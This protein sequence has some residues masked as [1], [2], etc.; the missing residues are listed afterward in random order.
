MVGG[1]RRLRTDHVDKT[2]RV[3]EILNIQEKFLHSVHVL[4]QSQCKILY[5]LNNGDKILV[6]T[7]RLNI[8]YNFHLCSESISSGSI[9]FSAIKYMEFIA[10]TYNRSVASVGKVKNLDYIGN[11]SIII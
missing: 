8:L 6:I 2:D 3:R 4:E 11:R 1:E 7:A 9:V 10:C 5:G